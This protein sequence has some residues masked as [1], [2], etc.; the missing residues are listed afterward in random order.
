MKQFSV[1]PKIT[2]LELCD[3]FIREYHINENDLI[4]TIEA[5]WTAHF[6]NVNAGTVVYI[7]KYGRGEPTD[8]MIEAI[9]RDIKRPYDRVIAIGGG[10]VLDCSKLFALKET[11]PVTDLFDKKIPAVKDKPLLLVP[12]TCGTG[13]EMTNIS[14]L[15]FKRRHTKFGLAAD[16]LYADEAILVPELLYNLPYKV[17]AASSIDALIHSLES[18][19]S[20]KATPVS[21]MFSAEAMRMILNGYKK[22]AAE[23]R[24][25][26]KSLLSDFSLASTMAGIAFGNAGCAAVHAMSY[27][28]GAEFHIPHGEAN[29]AM[30]TGVF[31]KY[32]EI[33]PDGIIRELNGIM[34]DV[35]NCQASG[36]Y[37]EVEQLLGSA[38]LPKKALR[39]YGMTKAQILEFTDSVI[40]N[41]QR[42]LSNN[43]VFLDRNALIEIYTRLF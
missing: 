23:G 32:M 42:L 15:E 17:F 12:T 41:Q 28:L 29:Y 38:I 27:P 36:V 9:S 34:A 7:E 5:A 14:I 39:E 25:V 8:E 20:P 18:Y 13:S 1:M 43:Y 24:D 11:V 6:Q 10:T 16:A 40:T 33:N 21:K 26:L 37:E 3:E 31:R 30:F 35:L 22:I 19:L 2:M 4:F